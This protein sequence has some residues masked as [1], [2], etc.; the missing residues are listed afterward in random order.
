MRFSGLVAAPMSFLLDPQVSGLDQLPDRRERLKDDER[1]LL[2]ASCGI[3][4][5]V[6]VQ[7]A[8]ALPQPF[9]LLADRGPAEHLAPDPAG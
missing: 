1:R 2:R 7:F 9:T 4:V 5:E 6:P 8:P 3:A